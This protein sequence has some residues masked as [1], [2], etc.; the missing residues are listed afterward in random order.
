MRISAFK[1][2]SYSFTADLW[3]FTTSTD[4]QGGP[5]LH[6]A[7]S[8]NIQLILVTGVFGKMTAYFKDSES[9]IVLNDQLQNIRDASGQEM[10]PGYIWVIDQFLPN[11]NIWGRREGFKG[12]VS[13]SGLVTG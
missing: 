4:A 10:N 1:N 3:T 2:K 9:D 11:I 8:R 7:L 13:Y 5:I 12:R 6:Y